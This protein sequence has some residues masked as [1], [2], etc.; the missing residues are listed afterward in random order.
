MKLI[1]YILTIFTSTL[2]FAQDAS[3]FEQAN[4]LYN[5]GEYAAAID[6]YESILDHEKHSAELYFNLANSHYKLNNIAPSIYYYEKALQLAPNDKDI[7]NNIVFARNMTID[8]IDT[9]PEVGFSKLLK[10]MSNWLDFD[11]WAMASVLLVMLFVLLFIM[12]YFSQST[13][14]KR[15]TFITSLASLLLACVALA[16]TFHNYN[17]VQKDHPA[18]VF[19]PESRV[20]SE[21]NLRSEESFRLHEG[22]KVQI[23]D[24]VNNW[25]EIQLSDGQTGWISNADIKAL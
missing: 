15:W 24:S 2:V 8:A 6:K 18:I 4:S 5:D 7:K 23:I 9:T 13:G 16:F 11:Q 21:P 10:N 25:N 14:H 12:Y 3:L 17:M 22:T 19:A 1:I 20:K